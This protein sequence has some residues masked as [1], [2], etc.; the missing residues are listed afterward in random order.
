M[1]NNIPFGYRKN[2]KPHKLDPIK[3][4]IA[5]AVQHHMVTG[6]DRPGL[7]QQPEDVDDVE[8]Q[9]VSPTE[10]L[11]RVKTREHGI[12]YFKIKVSEML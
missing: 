11:I 2:Q 8:G 1:P 7:M 6:K 10:T 4:M 12:R 3:E 9:I 5:Q